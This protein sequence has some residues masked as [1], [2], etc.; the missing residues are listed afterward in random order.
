MEG[1]KGSSFSFAEKLLLHL[2]RGPGTDDFP[3]GQEEWNPDNALSLLCRV[4]PDFLNSIVGKEILD[5]GCGTGWQSVA[6]AKAGASSVLGLEINPQTLE[7]ARH[8]AQ[9]L[10]LGPRVQFAERLDE[11]LEGRFGVVVSQNSMEHFPEPA[12]ALAQMKSALKPEGRI[13]ITFGPPWLSPYGA[14]MHFFTKV[15]WVNLLFSEKAVMNARAVFRDD[16]ARRYEEVESGLNRMT[17][18]KFER[19]VSYVGL[20][21]QYRRYDCVKKLNFLGKLPGLR[22]LFV[23]QISC[24]LT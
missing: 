1:D 13:L 20:Q 5:F 17:I 21:I 15:P 12:Q 24:V 9:E 11:S 14:H 3:A 19:T 7:K 23:N 6:L 2:S 4:F 10:G 16:Q 18:A 22:E 8:L